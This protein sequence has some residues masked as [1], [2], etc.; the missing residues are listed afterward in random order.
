MRVIGQKVF[1]CGPSLQKVRYQF[2]RYPRVHDHWLA[3]QSSR[4][5][6]NPLFPVGD[7]FRR[8]FLYFPGHFLSVLLFQYRPIAPA[9]LNVLFCDV[10]VLAGDRVNGIAPSQQLVHQRHGN[11][12]APDRR[13]AAQHRRITHNP[14]LPLVP[15]VLFLSSH[16]RAPLR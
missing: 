2:H 14:F 13:L 16:G 6:F 15:F 1:D 11:S 9:S 10:Q 8:P 4:N 3:A 12:S 5:A 7:P